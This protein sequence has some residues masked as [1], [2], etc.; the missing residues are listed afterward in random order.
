M[1]WGMT[2]G[3]AMRKKVGTL[4]VEGSDEEKQSNEIKFFAPTLEQMDIAGRTITAD[5]MNIQIESANYVIERG[6]D[7]HFS[8]KG[9][10][11][12]LLEDIQVWYEQQGQFQE[13]DFEEPLEKDHGRITQRKIWVT[14]QLNGYVK[15]PHVQ[16]VFVIERNVQDPKGKNP[17]RVEIVYGITSRSKEESN[18]EEI[19]STNRGHWAV[20]IAHH[21][22][23]NP[24]AFNEDGSRIRC[25]HGPENMACMRR[26]ALTLL[27]Y[28]QQRNRQPITEQIERLKYNP[29]RVL[30]YL[31]LTGNTRPRRRSPTE[32][33]PLSLAT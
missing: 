2:V 6:A 26:L 15:F 18:A 27:R 21:V 24:Q 14:D 3:F 20:E 11:P 25:G 12:G 5:A 9:N 22:L 32:C 17:D 23:D 1:E 13:P 4:P 29:R 19:L 7:F 31:K 16:Q 10:Q 33:W 8:V 30:D 28:Y